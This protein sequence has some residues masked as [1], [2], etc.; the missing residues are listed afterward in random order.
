MFTTNRRT[1]LLTVCINDWKIII[2]DTLVGRVLGNIRSR[3]STTTL[4]QK[5]LENALLHLSCFKLSRFY[6]FR[7]IDV[8]KNCDIVKTYDWL[9]I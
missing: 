5:S 6:E 9:V 3:V 7:G 1:L 8:S 4:L 2:D